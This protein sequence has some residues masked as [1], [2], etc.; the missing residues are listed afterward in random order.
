MTH[1]LSGGVGDRQA[2][3]G[4]NASAVF[5]FPD[6]GHWLRSVTQGSR[7]TGCHDCLRVVV[8]HA[9]PGFI[10]LDPDVAEGLSEQGSRFH[11]CDT[12]LANGILRTWLTAAK[13]GHD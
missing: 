13:V 1:I 9:W 5:A 7:L 4:E 8:K 10:A 3:C 6:A 11:A 12:D 2:L